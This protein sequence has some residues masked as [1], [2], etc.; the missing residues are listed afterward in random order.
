MTWPTQE[1]VVFETALAAAVR[2]RH[3]V[4]GFPSRLCSAPRFPRRAIAGGRL[5]SRPL[6]V[7][8]DDVEAAQLARALVAFLDLLAHVP[9]AAAN[10]PL[11]HAHVTAERP[12][13][14]LHGS[15]AP[16]ADRLAGVV[17]FRDAPLIG[18][19]DTRATSAHA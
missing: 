4:I 11:V 8:L 3:D 14:P 5:R 15:T 13:G 17:P 12:P 10:L 16:A 1:P 6:A 19:H 7:R 18:G 9:R 2:H